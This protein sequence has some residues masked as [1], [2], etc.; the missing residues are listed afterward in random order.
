MQK[1]ETTTN[2]T[3]E[4]LNLNNLCNLC[5]NSCNVNRNVNA[6]LCGVSN[7]L[8]IAKFY[9]HPFE[10]PCISGT[11]G[12]GTVFFTGCSLK[13]VFCQNYPLSRNQTGKEITIEELANVFKQLE[14][15]G[16]HNVNLVNPTH[17]ST[18][19]MQA[20][21]IYK[22]KIP[23]VYNTHG[24]ENLEILKKIDKYIDVY[25]P[26]IKFFSDKNAFR[27][28]GKSNYFTV[29]S[30]A[31]EFMSNKPIVFDSDGIMKSGTIVRHLILPL[32][33]SDSKNILDWF[34]KIKDNAYI[35]LM[36]QY[37]PYGEIENFAELK[38][39]ITKR[40]YDSVIDYALSLGIEKAFYQKQ[41][42]SGTNYI[43]KWDY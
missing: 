1:K 6:G 23:I 17:Y 9:L 13:C 31:I 36:S 27:Y 38:R 18:Q 29:A 42:S 33:V 35:N 20:L 11:R 43:P 4:H 22:P 3:L 15:M 40:E 14:D 37:T 34:V 30:K 24:Y 41:E 25:L 16:A 19:I 12:S 2:F 5:P 8:K 10:E 7:K 32:G 21:D 28:T 39:P 26:D